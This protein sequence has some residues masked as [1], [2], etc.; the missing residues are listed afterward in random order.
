MNRPMTEIMSNNLPY[1]KQGEVAHRYILGLYELL[2][3]LT[4]EFPHVLFESCASGGNRFDGGMLYY[5]PQGWT[6]DNTDA[7]DRLK[8][9]Y[10]T[11]MIYPLSSMGAH[12]SAV[13]NHQTGRITD[14]NFR[15]SVAYF[16]SF[17]YELDLN[18]IT[19][20]EQNLVKNQIIFMKNNRKLFQFGDFYRLRSPYKGENTSWMVVSTDKREAIVGDYT[21]LITAN[22]GF[23]RLKLTGLDPDLEYKVESDSSIQN[24]T[25][26]GD[27]LMNSGL[28]FGKT[29][30]G[31]SPLNESIGDFKSRIIK[32][33]A[34]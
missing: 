17:G 5:M 3:K 19:L 27:E 14:I 23:D 24:K 10:G 7:V 13:P 15:A 31:T 11:S 2:E 30:F 16:G 4:K 21:R 32:L 9:Q 12:I 34:I 22:Y 8:I 33:T 6:S 26:K 29:F 28:I 1:T 20:E 25:A 18:K